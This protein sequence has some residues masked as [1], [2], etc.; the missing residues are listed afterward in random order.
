MRGGGVSGTVGNHFNPWVP[1]KGAIGIIWKTKPRMPRTPRSVP[2][3][4]CSVQQLVVGRQGFGS[5]EWSEPPSLSCRSAYHAPAEHPKKKKYSEKVSTL[6]LCDTHPRPPFPPGGKAPKEISW[7][8]EGTKLTTPSV[9]HSAT[10]KKSQ[11]GYLG[12]INKTDAS[13]LH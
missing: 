1:Q 5:K 3:V 4:K 13:A 10:S 12:E 9:F 11:G 2:G 6:K 7:Y 8:V